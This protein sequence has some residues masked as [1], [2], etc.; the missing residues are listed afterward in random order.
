MAES[1]V[2]GYTCK[3]KKKKTLIHNLQ[4]LPWTRVP[5]GLVFEP[6]K[7]TWNHYN[8]THKLSMLIQT[9]DKNFMELQT[10]SFQNQFINQYRNAHL[11][12]L[13]Q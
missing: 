4:Y 5:S 7:Y 10:F 1:S 2:D 3:C 12:L 6:R 8:T 11:M 9:E 13:N